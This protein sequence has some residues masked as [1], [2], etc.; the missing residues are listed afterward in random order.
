MGVCD[1]DQS[2]PSGG[3]NPS[4]HRVSPVREA[5]VVTRRLSVGAAERVKL[6]LKPRAVCF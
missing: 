2:G 4:R 3:K 1:D 6:E 5:V